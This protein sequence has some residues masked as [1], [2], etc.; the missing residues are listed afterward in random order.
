MNPSNLFGL[1]SISFISGENCQLCQIWAFPTST[2]QFITARIPFNAGQWTALSL[3]FGAVV[4]IPQVSGS[5]TGTTDFSQTLSVM[6]AF[7]TDLDGNVVPDATF[8][9]VANGPEPVPEPASLL[10]LGTGLFGVVTARREKEKGQ[11]QP[12]WRI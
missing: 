11:S 3:D 9:I 5:G 1:W 2:P 4:N 8:E 12:S 10:L 7:A 6:S